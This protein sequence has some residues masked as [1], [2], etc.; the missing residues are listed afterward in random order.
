MLLEKIQSVH[1]ETAQSSLKTSSI[2]GQSLAEAQ[3]Q[4][5]HRVAGKTT[6]SMPS[7]IL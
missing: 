3:S 4:P 7:G 1:A 2:H 5:I 6:S